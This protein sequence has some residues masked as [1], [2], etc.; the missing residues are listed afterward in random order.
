MQV[1]FTDDVFTAIPRRT[2]ELCRGMVDRQLNLSWF[3][4][5]RADQVEYLHPI[6]TFMH[7]AYCVYVSVL[8]GCVKHPYIWLLRCIHM[9]A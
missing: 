7:Q 4:N 2:L 6:H 9:Q 5:A 8:R 1:S 3:C